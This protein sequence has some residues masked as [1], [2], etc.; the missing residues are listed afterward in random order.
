M[1]VVVVLL[2]VCLLMAASR[3]VLLACGICPRFCF[4]DPVFFVNK[5][6]EDAISFQEDGNMVNK[7]EKTSFDSGLRFFSGDRAGFL[8]A[9]DISRDR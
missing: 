3:L 9:L 5:T 6:E 8:K 2:H 1:V 4:T 7:A